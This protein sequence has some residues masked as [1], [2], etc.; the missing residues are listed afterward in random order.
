MGALENSKKL[1][2]DHSSTCSS[3]S[4]NDEDES[5]ASSTES[6]DQN[7]DLTI[8]QPIANK[9]KLEPHSFYHHML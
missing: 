6:D 9:T 1:S 4:I 7:M 3:Q 5:S 8:I 2:I